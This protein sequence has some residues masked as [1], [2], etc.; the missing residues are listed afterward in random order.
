MEIIR[1]YR[2]ALDLLTG[3]NFKELEDFLK[4]AGRNSLFSDYTKGHLDREVI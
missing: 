3:G 1:T 2:K 4:N